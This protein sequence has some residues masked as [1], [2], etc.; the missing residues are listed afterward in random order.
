MDVAQADLVWF[1]TAH[2]Q[3][4]L[5]G[6][7]QCANRRDLLGPADSARCQRTESVGRD[8]LPAARIL[9]RDRPRPVGVVPPR[10]SPQ[11]ERDLENEAARAA[12]RRAR[13]RQPSGVTPSTT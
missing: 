9:V 13:T 5:V 10:P 12:R 6:V 7:T 2:H 8:Q 1:N 11:M 3:V 4:L